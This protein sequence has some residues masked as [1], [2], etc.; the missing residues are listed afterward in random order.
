MRIGTGVSSGMR[1]YTAQITGSVVQLASATSTNARNNNGFT[2]LPIKLSQDMASASGS[3]SCVQGFN[4]RN[5]GSVTL[6]VVS[7]NDPPTSYLSGYP[8]LANESARVDVRDGQNTYL[9]T[10]AGTTTVAVWE[11]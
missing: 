7:S 11:V 5:T 4:I 2:T 10:Q 9:L 1:I 8:I 6:Y 3:S